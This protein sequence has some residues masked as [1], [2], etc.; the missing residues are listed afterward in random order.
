MITA[1]HDHEL[2]SR[3]SHSHLK[4]RYPVV[5]V[6]RV[7]VVAIHRNIVRRKKIRIAAVI[8]FILGGYVVKFCRRFHR[9]FVCYNVLVR[10][11]AVRQTAYAICRV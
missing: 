2:H 5:R 4:R 1:I 6:V 8:V 11:D 9:G 10:V 7:V 3:E